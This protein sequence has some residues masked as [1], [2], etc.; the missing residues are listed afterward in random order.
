MTNDF[1]YRHLLSDIRTIISSKKSVM[2]QFVARASENCLTLLA[3]TIPLNINNVTLKYEGS[4]FSKGFDILFIFKLFGADLQLIVC[5]RGHYEIRFHKYTP[6]T[7]RVLQFTIGE[8]EE[9]MS[10]FA[11][12]YN[13]H[14]VKVE[15]YLQKLSR[16]AIFQNDRKTY[17]ILETLAKDLQTVSVVI[18]FKDHRF[19]IS[20]YID[21]A[22]RKTYILYKYGIGF[23]AKNKLVLLLV[24][25]PKRYYGKVRIDAMTFTMSGNLI[26]YDT[27]KENLSTVDSQALMNYFI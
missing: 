13:A 11:E 25:N 22:T 14:V 17:D 21:S 15:P 3:E 5:R 1:D 10:R 23:R 24:T 20:K 7:M 18:G 4:Y 26:Q 16:F 12:L 19:P 27:L 2:N 6:S 9:M 8:E